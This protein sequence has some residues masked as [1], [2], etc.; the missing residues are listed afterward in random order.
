MLA[1]WKKDCGGASETSG[2]LFSEAPLAE[3]LVAS[4]PNHKACDRAPTSGDD[5]GCGESKEEAGRSKRFV[6]LRNVPGHADPLTYGDITPFVPLTT[7][8][9]IS[10]PSIGSVRLRSSSGEGQPKMKE[11]STGQNRRTSRRK[12]RKII[13][14]DPSYNTHKSSRSNPAN[15]QEF[16]KA[17]AES[18]TETSRKRRG[19]GDETKG[20]TKRR[21]KAKVGA[22]GFNTIQEATPTS[23]RKGNGHATAKRTTQDKALPSPEKAQRTTQD[24]ALPSP[25]KAQ[26]TKEDKALPTPKK[27]Q[28]TKEDKVMPLVEEGSSSGDRSGQHVPLSLGATE[29]ETQEANVIHWFSCSY[30]DCEYRAKRKSSL[31]RH[32]NGIHLRLRPHACNR[33]G[34]SRRFAHR[35]NL[36]RH[37]RIHT[38]EKPFT[39]KGCGKKFARKSDMVRMLLGFLLWCLS[40]FH[41][42]RNCE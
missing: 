16:G 5:N 17:D 7:V 2:A 27:A 15:K 31:K 26:R 18:A 41:A 13:F 1:R 28:R 3:Y 42:E 39:C 9:L 11:G 14:Y 40:L 21:K 12:R 37:I 22:T 23:P 34:C 6:M 20:R 4:S 8:G 24:K 10:P 32:I 36:M 38:K 19:V 25:K 35:G 30:K 33:K 29:E